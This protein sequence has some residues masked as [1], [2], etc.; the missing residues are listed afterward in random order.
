M[1]LPTAFLKL[2][3]AETIPFPTNL[4]P[5]YARAESGRRAERG[6]LAELAPDACGGG[7]ASLGMLG[8][9]LPPP[10]GRDWRRSWPSSCLAACSDAVAMLL[11][12]A[13]KEA[14]AARLLDEARQLPIELGNARLVPSSILG[15]HLRPCCTQAELQ[16]LAIPEQGVALY[17]F[18]LMSGEMG[19]A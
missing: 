14:A 12:A 4:A 2:I 7:T 13:Q 6:P 18:E 16:H 8:G 19:I 1:L 3:G 5:E 9:G 17:V 11:R 15:W 10:A